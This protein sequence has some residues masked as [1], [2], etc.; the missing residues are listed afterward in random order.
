MIGLPFTAQIVLFANAEISFQT[1]FLNTKLPLG[2][3]YGQG[4]N[5]W[6]SSP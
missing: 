1:S 6:K 4:V 5:A 3:E 2:P